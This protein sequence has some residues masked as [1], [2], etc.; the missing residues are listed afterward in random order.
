MKKRLF[1]KIASLC[2][3]VFPILSFVFII[4]LGNLLQGYSHTENY[5]S[6]IWEVG[7]LVGMVSLF[8]FMPLSIIFFI[9]ITGLYFAVKKDK[10]SWISFVLLV[11]FSLTLIFMVVFPCDVGCELGSFNGY[12]H[13]ISMLIGFI[14]LSLAPLFFWFATRQDKRWKKYSLYNLITPLIGL[15]ALVI[16]FF[17]SRDL[18]GITQRIYLLVYFIWIEVIALK[19]FKLSTIKSIKKKK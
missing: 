19:L 13:N 12:I 3:L 18:K 8:L 15:V 10:Y 17:C 2:G 11:I 5:I 6:E 7:S 4:L 1:I 9:F 14:S 16:F